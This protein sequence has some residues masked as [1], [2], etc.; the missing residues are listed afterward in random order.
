MTSDELLAL[1]RGEIGDI[2][3]PY[4]WTDTEGYAFM[5]DAQRMFCRLT[6]GLADGSTPAVTQVVAAPGDTWLDLHPS[7]KKI[8]AANRLSDGRDVEVVNFED[9]ATRGLRFNGATG[10]LRSIVVGI[11]ENKARALRTVSEPETLELLVFRL[12]IT[13]ITGTDQTFEVA[14]QHHQHLMLWMK[15]RAYMKQ[16][17]ECFDR[18]KAEEFDAAF[19]A[20]CTLAA[21]EQRDKRHKIRTVAYG[22]L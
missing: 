7:I 21:K 17:A 2:V 18:S 16:D 3:A 11:E 5:D 10:P 15:H 12:P 4:L 6:D 19:R 9:M 20:Y 13:T 8:R 14:E 22:G 1:W